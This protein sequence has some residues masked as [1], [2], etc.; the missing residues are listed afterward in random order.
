MGRCKT[1]ARRTLRYHPNVPLSNLVIL[2][3]DDNVE[4]NYALAHMLEQQGHCEVVRA[5]SGSE[6]LEL[7]TSHKPSA[8][9]LDV[10]L[11]D[12]NGWEVCRKMRAD[13]QLADVPIVFITAVFQ[14][15]AAKDMARSVGGNTLLFYPVQKDQL[16]AVIRGEIARMHEENPSS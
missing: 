3:V 8:I 1:P 4:H 10:D 2:A 12:V 16:F 7:A 6:A 9:L 5:Y 13:P 14:S 11:P 15:T